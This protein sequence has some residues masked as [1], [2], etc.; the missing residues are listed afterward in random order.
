[1]DRRFE[2]HGV[3]PD[4]SPQ[5]W[6][7]LVLSE[8]QERQLSP[9]RMTHIWPKNSPT[10]QVLG[11]AKIVVVLQSDGAQEAALI[12][13]MNERFLE[14]PWNRQGLRSQE[15]RADRTN[16]AMRNER[17]ADWNMEEVWERLGTDEM[18]KR[19]RLRRHNGLH[20]GQAWGRLTNILSTSFLYQ[21]EHF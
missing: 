19:E 5:S 14:Y 12:F 21:L 6:V 18:G 13:H 16:H 17:P 20:P 7:R 1:M 11:P 3:A 8:L 15:P 9:S 10:N 2:I 4:I